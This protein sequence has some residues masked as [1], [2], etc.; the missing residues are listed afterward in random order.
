LG[1]KKTIPIDVRVIATS[2]RNLLN[3]V[4]ENKFREDLYYSLNVIPLSWP[5]LRDRK[6]D[7]IPIAEFLLEKHAM[8]MQKKV[9]VISDLAKE[10]LLSHSWP[11]NVRELENSI[12]RALVFQS[13]DTVCEHDFSFSE[14]L[15]I[16]NNDGMDNED[17]ECLNSDIKKHE[18]KLI[19]KTLKEC[20]GNR[21]LMAEKLGISPRTLRYK[22]AKMR[23]EGLDTI[24]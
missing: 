10:K 16:Q 12:Q 15:G 14:I 2:N 22:L 23:E 1:A 3:A 11:G 9:P 13:G 20:R 19:S 7:I 24:Y 6:Q 8:K 18:Y 21:K 17:L 5:A 4:K